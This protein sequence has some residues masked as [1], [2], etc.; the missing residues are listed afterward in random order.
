MNIPIYLM[1][2]ISANQSN[3]GRTMLKLLFLS[4]SGLCLAYLRSMSVSWRGGVRGG[5]TGGVG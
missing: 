4:I 3:N 2:P 1:M 5:E